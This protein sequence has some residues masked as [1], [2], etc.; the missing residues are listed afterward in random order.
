MP[1]SASWTQFTIPV[2]LFLLRASFLI[3][4]LS[5]HVTQKNQPLISYCILGVTVD[6]DF[7]EVVETVHFRLCTSSSFGE[8]LGL[9]A[10]SFI[11]TPF[12]LCESDRRQ[13]L[14]CICVHFFRDVNN[15]VYASVLVQKKGGGIVFCFFFLWPQS[16][17]GL[18]TQPLC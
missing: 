14:L 9:W 17:A 4:R 10:V 15:E 12:T 8:L 6:K 11:L 5:E 2:S 16:S 13:L 7:C 3:S 1:L 18:K